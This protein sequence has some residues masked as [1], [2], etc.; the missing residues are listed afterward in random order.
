M[1]GFDGGWR[2]WATWWAMTAEV[3][4]LTVSLGGAY[5]ARLLS[6]GGLH[7]TRAEPPEG[8]WLRRWSASGSTM[9]DGG[10]GALFRWLAG[11]QSS[12]V[13]TDPAELAEPL[14]T[15]DAVLWA[16]GAPVGLDTAQAACALVVA[17]SS[18][19]TTGPWADR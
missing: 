15:A 19:G 1:P 11:G 13:V 2:R 9:P 12:L 10:D 18:F 8:H 4:D 6:A 5:A 14:R 16:P 17:V 3:L 7:V